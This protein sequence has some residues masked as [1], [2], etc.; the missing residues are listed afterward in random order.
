MYHVY[1][2]HYKIEGKKKYFLKTMKCE[3][4]FI[5]ISFND[6]IHN[7]IDIYLGRKW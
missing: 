5:N 2:S 3:K 7:E 1:G 6:K 4:M